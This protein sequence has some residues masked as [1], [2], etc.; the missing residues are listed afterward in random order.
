MACARSTHIRRIGSAPRR[1]C[2]HRPCS[3]R[4]AALAQDAPPA[5]AGRRRQRP[6]RDRATATTIIVTATKRAEESAGR[7]DRDHR[8]RHQDARRAAGRRL[9]RLCQAGPVA[10]RTSPA[11]APGSDATSTC[12][13]SP[14]GENGNHSASLPSVGTYLDE[15]PITTIQGALD[16]HIFDIAR[17][18]ALAGPQGTLYGASSQAGTIR[19]ITN[20]P[21]TQRHLR[22]G[23]PRAEQGRPRRLGLYRRRLRQ[24]AGLP[25]NIAAARRRLV[26]ARR[27][28]H[29]QHP[30]ARCTFPT[31]AA[32]PSRQ[33]RPRRR[34]L[35]RRRHLRRPRRAEDRPQ[36][37]LDGH[38]RRSWGRS[39]RANGTFARGTRARRPR[40]HAVQPRE[41]QGQVVQAAL[42]VEGK[43]GNFD[44]TYAGALHEARGR[45]RSSTIPTTP[46]STTRSPATAPI[47]T[48]MTTIWSTRPSTSR[49]TTRFTQACRTSCASPRRRTSALRLVAGL[50]YQ[51]QTHNIEQNYI[52]DDLADVARRAGHRRATSG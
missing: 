20:K 42:T 36:R 47:A 45:R 7:A 15:Q 23:Q 43:I 41:A 16:I 3:P 30:R 33:R 2:W 52:I 26:P 6:P 28:L 46:T 21:D 12:A 37:Q 38:A 4:R 10:C 35:Q 29:R 18:E 17:V 13:A 32:S 48:T 31:V 19:I 5:D 14:A 25:S 8:A 24:P 27:R 1:R 44:L 51:R 39:R 40:D 50:F 9:R 11:A 22:R 49:A 34:R